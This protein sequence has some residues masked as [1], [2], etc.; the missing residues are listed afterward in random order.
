MDLS[1]SERVTF[2]CRVPAKASGSGQGN[3]IIW[4]N[5]N[6]DNCPQDCFHDSSFGCDGI[7]TIFEQCWCNDTLNTAEGE[8]P[9]GT[10]NVTFTL[11]RVSEVHIGT[12]NCQHQ[13]SGVST[14]V[15]LKQYSMLFI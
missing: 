14:D 12:W 1:A 5:P 7:K 9:Y 15:Q 4:G 13:L 3:S 2:S 8:C 6:Q 11:L 10:T